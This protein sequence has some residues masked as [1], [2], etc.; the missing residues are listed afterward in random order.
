MRGILNGRKK[1]HLKSQPKYGSS[2]ETFKET[3][4]FNTFNSFLC[5]YMS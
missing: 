1:A 5:N 2:I 4:L 3:N